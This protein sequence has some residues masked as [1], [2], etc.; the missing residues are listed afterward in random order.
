MDRFIVYE[1][2]LCQ[3]YRSAVL[4]G[5]DYCSFDAEGEARR[6][7]IECMNH[8]DLNAFY[9]DTEAGLLSD[10]IAEKSFKLDELGL[11][12]SDLM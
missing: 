5:A 6:E 7:C 1:R 12:E 10:P 3:S 4:R 9:I 8:F 11:V 2:S